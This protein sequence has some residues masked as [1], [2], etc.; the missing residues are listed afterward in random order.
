MKKNY[1][2][3]N[4]KKII[5]K[6]SKFKYISFDMFDT[7]IKRD[8][9]DPKEVFL[10]IER[11]IDKKYGISSNF[12]EIRVKAE[13]NVR[14]N[15][16]NE[17]IKLEEI[18]D[19]LKNSFSDELVMLAYNLEIETEISICH[20]NPAMLSV[21][22]YCINNNKK[23]VITT[24]IYLSV[25]VIKKILDDNHINYDYLFVSSD[26]GLTKSTGNLFK[27]AL[28]NLNIT[29]KEIIHIGDNFKSDYI[30]SLKNNIKAIKIPNM[31]LK[32]QFIN[33]EEFR[34]NTDYRNLIY[35]INNR[36]TNYCN[37]TLYS[38][39]GYEVHGI[40]LYGFAKWL[41]K[42]ICENKF[43]KVFFLSR[44]G[45]IMK[46]AYDI[47]SVNNNSDYMYASR[48]ALIVPTL[49]M[50]S[51]IDHI[52]NVMFWP[53]LGTISSFIQKI[54]L[55]CNSYMH[56]FSEIGYHIDNVYEYRLLF[57]DSKFL[58]VYNNVIK[59]DVISNSKEEYENLVLYL[60]QIGF[61]GN[62][63]VIDIGWN[64]NMQLA[65]QKIVSVAEIDAHIEGFYLGLNPYSKNII[66]KEIS[67]Q[68]YLFDYNYNIDLFE[69]E[70]EFNCILETLFTANHGSVI[71]FQN[72]GDEIIPVLDKWEYQ[73]I[74]DKEIYNNIL[75][76]QENSLKFIYDINNN[77]MFNNDISPNVS[78]ANFI[79]LGCFSKYVVTKKIGEMKMLGTEVVYLAKPKHSFGYYIFNINKLKKEFEQSY[80]RIGFLTNLFKHN[81]GFYIFL[82]MLRKISRK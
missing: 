30:Y 31:I 68:G 24:D 20:A 16:S 21:V 19:E 23:I 57:K 8:F 59:K 37:T 62:V 36:Y 77:K 38:Q 22:N 80:W 81:F 73:E 4:T 53:R 13:L 69:K 66:D 79:E 5:S 60:K 58:D 51:E 35:Y 72:N 11:L 48:R 2:N 3:F 6:V 17:E 1:S 9:S 49:W 32:N 78:F 63:A 34:N 12:K 61:S 43:D 15:K 45:Q 50:N 52:A 74:A 46:K 71:K 42:K 56:L 82:Q 54:G 55:D 47:I 76:V 70:K 40:L 27:Y 26:V 7:L 44:D 18:Y 64:G 75:L 67:A 33:D 14:Q 25:D 10:R 28:K 41:N 39:L 29:P 65:L